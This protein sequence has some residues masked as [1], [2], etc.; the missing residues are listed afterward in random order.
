MWQVHYTAKF[1]QKF[2]VSE[3]SLCNLFSINARRKLD[4]LFA[5]YNNVNNAIYIMLYMTVSFAQ[6]T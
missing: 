2:I 3:N 4:E 5:R 6:I 1:L